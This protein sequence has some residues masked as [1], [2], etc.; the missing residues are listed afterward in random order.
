MNDEVIECPFCG[1]IGTDPVIEN[2]HSCGTFMAS[3]E[4]MTNECLIRS[5]RRDQ[6]RIKETL[7][8]LIEL[9]TERPS[10]TPD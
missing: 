8:K 9:L 4:P 7:A 6:L 3:N 5:I 10:D 2:R 1:S